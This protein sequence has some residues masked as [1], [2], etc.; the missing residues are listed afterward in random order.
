MPDTERLTLSK[1]SYDD[2]AF[3][4]ELL[5]EPAFK[6]FIGD[7]GVRSLGDARKYLREGPI[8]QYERFGYGLYRVSLRGSDVVT[9]ICGLVKRDEFPDPDL[10]FAFLEVHWSNGYAFEASQ[11]ILAEATQRFHLRRILAMADEDNNASNRLL[12]KLGFCFEG[13]VVMPGDTKEIRQYAIEA[14]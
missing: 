2:A 6:E 10:G 7:K 14:R 12:D 1:L 8:S 9:G 4:L 3:I 5:N 11:A 13:M